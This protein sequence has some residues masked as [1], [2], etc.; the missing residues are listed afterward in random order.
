MSREAF[1]VN[2]SSTAR[3]SIA[4]R[5]FKHNNRISSLFL[6]YALASAEVTHF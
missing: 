5:V 2:I 4:R 6:R 1:I 3:Q